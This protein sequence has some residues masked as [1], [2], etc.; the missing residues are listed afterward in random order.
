MSHAAYPERGINAIETMMRIAQVVDGLPVP[1]DALLGRGIIVLT[2]IISVPYPGICSVPYGCQATYIRRVVPGE[3]EDDLLA[4]IE[5][6]IDQAKA[7]DPKIEATVR[8]GV[9]SFRAYTGASVSAK[10]FAP[11]WKMDRSSEIVLKSLGGLKAVGLESGISKWMFAT[12]G[13]YTAGIRG[14]PTVGFGPGSE[15]T[16]HAS[17]EYVPVAEL[18]RAAAGCYGIGRAL[19]S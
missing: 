1:E 17:D 3:C 16:A 18:A 2:G 19:L 7:S 14:I 4:Q 10:A 12:N 9:E 5:G 6:A 13:S 11:A 15:S 8:I